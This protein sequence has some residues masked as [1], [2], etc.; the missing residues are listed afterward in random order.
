MNWHSS[1]K[2]LMNYAGGIISVSLQEDVSQ[3]FSIS[4]HDAMRLNIAAPCSSKTISAGEAAS[5]IG[6]QSQWKSA[7]GKL[8]TQGQGI[9]E[10]IR[11]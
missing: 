11:H 8:A 10:I 2:E 9:S 6:V 3:R 7:V 5:S 4:S 1:S